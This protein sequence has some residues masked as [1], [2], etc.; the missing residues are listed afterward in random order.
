MKNATDTN[1]VRHGLVSVADL[2]SN[3]GS[4]AN[5]VAL[6]M[7]VLYGIT[8]TATD[9]VPAATAVNYLMD[10]HARIYKGSANR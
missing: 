6:N 2:A 7:R 1:Y 9:A 8:T 5:E 3:V 4:T 10:G